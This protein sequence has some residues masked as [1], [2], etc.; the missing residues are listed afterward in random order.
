MRLLPG[1]VAVCASA[2]AAEAAMNSTARVAR[3]N[4]DGV[5][6][7]IVDGQGIALI[8]RKQ[9]CRCRGLPII[10]ERASANC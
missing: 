10:S 2:V 9:A 1:V 7:R 8:Q 6:R 4:V 3:L 5:G